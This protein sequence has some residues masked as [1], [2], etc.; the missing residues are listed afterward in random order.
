MESSSLT[1]F[2]FS[3]LKNYLPQ[4]I[5]WR[6]FLIGLEWYGVVLQHSQLRSVY[7]AVNGTGCQLPSKRELVR[8]FLLTDEDVLESSTVRQHAGVDEHVQPHSIHHHFEESVAAVQNHRHHGTIL[9]LLDP[10]LHSDALSDGND[11]VASV[12]R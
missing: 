5:V 10:E 8:R 3:C 4:G 12:G 7:D 11:R 6:Y 2:H 9:A 1:T